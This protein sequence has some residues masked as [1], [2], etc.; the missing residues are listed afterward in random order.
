[1]LVFESVS[2]AP[3]RIVSALKP[4]WIAAADSQICNQ[5]SNE[6]Q[7]QQSRFVRELATFPTKW[8]SKWHRRE[9][10]VA[11]ETMHSPFC[12]DATTPAWI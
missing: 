2:V 7:K 3:Y 9:M 10:E 5:E 11:K 12:S 4:K 8:S 1:M 6:F